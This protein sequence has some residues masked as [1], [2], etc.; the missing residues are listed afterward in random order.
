MATGRGNPSARR[1]TSVVSSG[2]TPSTRGVECRIDLTDRDGFGEAE[3]VSGKRSLADIDSLH[4]EFNGQLRVAV[5]LGLEYADGTIYEWEQ[6]DGHTKRQRGLDGDQAVL[7]GRYSDSPVTIGRDD[8]VFE[9]PKTGAVQ[10]LADRV[11][12]HDD[13]PAR[14]VPSISGGSSR[15]SGEGRSF[16]TTLTAF[17]VREA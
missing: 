12:Q 6:L 4:V 16:T 11:D 15:F 1:P 7:T 8:A 13:V 9:D 10:S 3:V 2:S 14:V 17:E 5:Q